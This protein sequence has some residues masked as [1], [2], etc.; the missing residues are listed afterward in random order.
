LAA[1]RCSP[2]VSNRPR[3]RVR[4]R[5]PVLLAAAPLVGGVA[6][7]SAASDSMPGCLASFDGSITRLDRDYGYQSFQGATWPEGACFDARGA[8][9]TSLVDG[10]QRRRGLSPIE[11]GVDWGRTSTVAGQRCA[12]PPTS[13]IQVADHSGHNCA[14]CGMFMPER[15][16]PP[17]QVICKLLVPRHHRGCGGR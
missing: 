14:A 7:A 5:L 16:R 4:A 3:G 15:G 10:A 2:I 11:I 13:M 12:L 8:S 1:A 6:A 17:H 9:W